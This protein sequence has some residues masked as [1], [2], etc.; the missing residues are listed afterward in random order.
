MLYGAALVGGSGTVEYVEIVLDVTSSSIAVNR[1][2]ADEG[3]GSACSTIGLPGWD[4]PLSPDSGGVSGIRD[5]RAVL[6][7]E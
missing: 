4:E 7:F 1:L 2:A 3:D 6:G 5:E